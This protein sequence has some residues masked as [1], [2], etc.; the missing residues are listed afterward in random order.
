MF[1]LNHQKEIEILIINIYY[2][3]LINNNKELNWTY[4]RC[5]KV[6]L[7][8][9]KWILFHSSLQTCKQQQSCPVAYEFLSE[10]NKADNIFLIVKI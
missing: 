9:S 7:I 10:I 5:T 4:Y 3:L 2:L 1:Y 6:A 8:W